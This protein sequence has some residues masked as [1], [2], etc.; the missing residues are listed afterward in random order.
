MNVAKSS[1]ATGTTGTAEPARSYCGR[2]APSPTGP[3]HFGSLLAAV[4]SYLEARTPRRPLA[5]SSSRI[6]TRRA[7]VPGP[8]IGFLRTSSVSGSP[9][10]GR[11]CARARAQTPTIE[12]ARAIEPSR[13]DPV[14]CLHP[15]PARVRSADGGRRDGG[16]ELFHPAVCVNPPTA[17]HRG[18]PIQDSGS[19]RRV[20]RPMPGPGA[21]QRRTR[22][23]DPSCC[24][25]AMGSLPI[26]SPSRSM[27][28]SRVSP[29]WCAARPARLHSAP[30]TAAG[31]AGLRPPGVSAPAPC[32][33]R[34]RE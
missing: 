5:G 23:S 20:R 3:L 15:Q 22:P 28:P 26:S 11:C 2:F 8:P 25:D 27:T 7:S 4:G 19:C 21:R 12:T 10:T 9:G 14:L 30:D 6:S 29:M 34:G 31:G 1:S 33:G 24:A 18:D 32:R 17:V 13:A 16:D